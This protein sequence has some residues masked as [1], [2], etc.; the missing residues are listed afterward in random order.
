MAGGIEPKTSLTLETESGAARLSTHGHRWPTIQHP[1]AKY[2]YTKE[3]II[4]QGLP[5]LSRN[6]L[7]AEAIS[8]EHILHTYSLIKALYEGCLLPQQNKIQGLTSKLPN[9]RAVLKK[10]TKTVHDLTRTMEIKKTRY[11]SYNLNKPSPPSKNKGHKVTVP[12]LQKR[13]DAY[14]RFTMLT[15]TG[16]PPLRVR[17]RGRG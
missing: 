10:Q 7:E 9:E 16:C 12:N 5:K 14:F 11:T 4:T 8:S 1:L 13:T 3:I 17:S 2:T 15:Q 6:H